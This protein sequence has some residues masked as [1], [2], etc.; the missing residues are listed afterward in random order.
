[1]S[2]DIE[3]MPASVGI[4]FAG[5]LRNFGKLCLRNKTLTFGTVILTVIFCMAI[6]AP[7]LGTIDPLT[8]SPARRLRPPSEQF[9]FGTDGLGR[10]VYSRTLYGA[11]ISLLVGF[12]VAILSVAIGL[13]LGLV[14]GFVRMADNV[15]MRLID[16]IMSIPPVMLAIALM[17]VVGTSVVN[18]IIAITVAE[19]LAQPGWSE[20][21]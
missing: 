7:W 3:M 8:I 17:A 14:S 16:G 18:V 5:R 10:D 20:V 19:I 2:A 1:M 21:S 12:S 13:F 11:R 4:G 15:I 9:W 6:F